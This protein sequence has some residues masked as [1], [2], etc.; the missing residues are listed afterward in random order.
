MDYCDFRDL[1]TC[2]GENTTAVLIREL[3]R[4]LDQ[5]AKPKPPVIWFEANACSGD[6]I[7]LF[8]AAGPG[9]EQILSSIIDLRYSNALMA[10][11]GPAAIEE[12]AA[13]ATANAGVFVLVV[14]GAIPVAARGRYGIVSWRGPMGTAGDAV[15]VASI[16][17]WLGSL[18]GSVVAVGT[19][20][21]HGG[22]S[23]ARPNP[24]GSLGT[25]AALGRRDVINV[26][27]CPAHPDWTMATL[28]H[29]LMYGPP[30]LDRWGRPTLIYGD[31]V[32]RH[33]QRR[34]YF[35]RGEFATGPGRRECMFE[36]GCVGPVTHSDCPYRQW[37]SYVN[38]PVKASTP[39]IGC[40][41]PEFPDG[42][43]PF[44][45]PLPVKRPG[46]PPGGHKEG[47]RV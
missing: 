43:T 34:S 18:A 17:E 46:S 42:S 26:T 28:A 13:A 2:S 15:T 37:N 44:F 14:E 19:C 25:S 47:I 20:A 3:N 16:V 29:L 38:W 21:T 22:P 7:S 4:F 35:D 11:E 8:N 9:L 27:G 41:T 5:A 10:A 6:S 45:A 33:C 36:A 40:T 39:C 12:L 31:T 23:A 24:S 32:H 1:V 30:G